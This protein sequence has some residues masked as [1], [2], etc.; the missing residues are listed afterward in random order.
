MSFQTIHINKYKPK[1]RFDQNGGGFLSVSISTVKGITS[2]YAC[3]SNYVCA[4]VTGKNADRLL[5]DVGAKRTENG[6]VILDGRTEGLIQEILHGDLAAIIE[7]DKLLARQ[8]TLYDDKHDP[9]LLAELEKIAAKEGITLSDSDDDIENELA[10]LEAEVKEELEAKKRK[11]LRGGSITDTIYAC[12]KSTGRYISHICFG[13][14]ENTGD[15]KIGE[16]LLEKKL[17]EDIA[18]LKEAIQF[19][20]T[21]I[22]LLERQ[23]QQNIEDAKT[24]EGKDLELVQK[25]IKKIDRE[26]QVHQNQALMN[27]RLLKIKKS[28]LDAIKR[29]VD[30]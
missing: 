29:L 3:V 15:K 26:K 13:N 18:K 16:N 7:R 28:Q 17:V 5:D 9:E 30:K 14:S 1:N 24:M 11:S 27:G 10:K 4:L 25:N 21:H 8:I 22:K 23:K 12:A 19:S 6:E 2:I 20:F